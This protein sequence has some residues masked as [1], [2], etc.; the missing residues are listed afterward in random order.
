VS[1]V[2]IPAN[3]A[4][5]APAIPLARSARWRDLLA[6]TRP[7]QW[8]KNLLVVAL[9]LLYP[10]VWAPGPLADLSVA[11]LL[12][13]LASAAV[14]IGNDLFDRERDRLHSIKCQRP[15]ASGRVSPRQA[16]ALGCVMVAL[17][18]ILTFTLAPK[19][20]LPI[21]AYLALNAAY[22]TGLRNVPMI[23]V[24]IV[25]LGFELRIVAGYLATGLPLR[26]W[27]PPSVFLLCLALVLGKRH[28]ELELAG[29]VHR[30]ALRDY[31]AG[32]IDQLLI[33]SAGLSAVT[34]LLFLE[35]YHSAEG[36]GGPDG[37]A[38]LLLPPALLGLF[39]YLQVVATAGGGADPVRTLL[40]DRLIVADAVLCLAILL[41]TRVLA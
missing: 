18:A 3:A 27:L 30:P 6:L 32:L 29:P 15:L 22:S 35:D 31:T 33:L 16:I 10:V 7:E 23:D 8:A 2:E 4:E 37:S 28:R 20:V 34:F 9:P 21:G 14:Y 25:A 13:T 12:F 11:V 39:R 41:G 24:F 1:T 36:G 17:L 26:G 40:R 38:L 19:L 5:P